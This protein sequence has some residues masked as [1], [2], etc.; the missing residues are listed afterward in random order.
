MA[1]LKKNRT[2]TSDDFYM[3]IQLACTKLLTI[4]Q[5]LGYNSRANDLNWVVNERLEGIEATIISHIDDCIERLQNGEEE[6]RI[7]GGM[8]SVEMWV[9]DDKTVGISIKFDLL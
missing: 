7:S 5:A 4:F 3:E 8:I 9:E 6:V 1:K 2:L